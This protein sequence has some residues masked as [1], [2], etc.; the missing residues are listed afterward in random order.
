VV[1]EGVMPGTESEAER[2][3]RQAQRRSSV[4]RRFGERRQPERAVAGRRVLYVGDRRT[5]ERRITPSVAFQPA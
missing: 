4:D 3:R 1:R 5:T 2:E